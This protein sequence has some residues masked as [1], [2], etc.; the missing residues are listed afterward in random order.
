MRLVVFLT[1]FSLAAWGQI[2]T[3]NNGQ[4]NKNGGAISISTNGA[5]MSLQWAT[6]TEYD[7]SGNVV[8][9]VDLSKHHFGWS[10]PEVL[11]LVVDL[12]ETKEHFPSVNFTEQLINGAWFNV[13]A[14]LI[15]ADS[16]LTRSKHNDVK[17]NVNIG[18][19]PWQASSNREQPWG[20]LV[21]T[22]GLVG[23]G[24]LVRSETNKDIHT[25]ATTATA[26]FGNGL[27]SSPLTA[28]YDGA[29]GPVGL[30]HTLSGKP[31]AMWSFGYFE[32]SMIYDPTASPT[33]SPVSTTNNGGGNVKA[34]SNPQ[35]SSGNAKFYGDGNFGISTNGAWMS[36]QWAT[37]EEVDANGNVL[38]SVDLSK[39]HFGWSHPEVLPIA[40]DNYTLTTD[41][42]PSVNFTEQ[43]ENGAWFN[44]TA[45]I[46]DRDANNSAAKHGS[47][48]WSIYISDWPWSP[49]QT[50]TPG[51][52]VLT[53]GLVGFGGIV[54][55]T[56]N[57]VANNNYTTQQA[58]YGT[59][60]LSSPSQAVYDGWYGP[61][62]VTHTLSGKPVV[63]WTFGHFSQYM[64][65]DPDMNNQAN[66][67][68]ENVWR[69]DGPAMISIYTI[70]GILLIVA[71]IGGIYF[72]SRVKTRRDSTHAKYR[73][74][75]RQQ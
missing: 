52:L 27:L 38:M 57:Q 33:T 25:A 56:D 63:S 43:L 9:S 14:W 40:L 66:L 7:Q 58:T 1:L 67:A 24:G 70:L 23:F 17:W 55:S 42:F 15:N 13:T 61:V 44:V 21:L 68:S 26:T 73:Q 28:F 72:T 22:A 62:G 3:S 71:L 8:Q 29:E 37:L 60:F 6:L 75:S 36:L 34:P 16:N 20:N 59:G 65:Y 46:L 18:N 49:A 5:W 4:F 35:A 48:K 32:S 47:V 74:S 12:T 54:R 31:E 11:P 69:P 2:V 30:T 19:W 10:Q 50:E 41:H 45:W 64:S 39:H 53:A 51:N